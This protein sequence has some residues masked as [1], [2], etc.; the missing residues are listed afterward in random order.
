M[1]WMTAIFV[2]LFVIAVELAIYIGHMMSWHDHVHT[3]YLMQDQWFDTICDQI[4]IFRDHIDSLA[5]KTK[6]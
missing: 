3:M 5:D 2:A 1:N 4:R 6:R